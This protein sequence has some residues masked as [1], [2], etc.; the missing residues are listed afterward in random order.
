MR[1]I[2]RKGK[3]LPFLVPEQKLTKDCYNQK[4]PEKKA[5][6][7]SLTYRCGTIIVRGINQ[8]IRGNELILIS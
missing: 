8:I 3:S 5:D 4:F 7:Q 2:F 1:I 6:H